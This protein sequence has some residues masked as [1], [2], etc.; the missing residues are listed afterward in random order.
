MNL[1][2]FFFKNLAPELTS[3]ANLLLLFFF[4]LP[5]ALQYI[6]VHSSCRSFW[7]SSVGHHVSMA[8]WV[9]PWPRSGSKP[10]KPWATGAVC[11]IWTTQ[12]QGRPLELLHFYLWLVKSP[13]LILLFVLKCI[14]VCLLD[15]KIITPA[16]NIF[17]FLSFL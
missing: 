4:F 12:P 14:K 13:Y 9:I 3:T 2:S 11:V 17:L 16:W 15:I 10:A 7:L 5:K 6:A 1:F 8:W